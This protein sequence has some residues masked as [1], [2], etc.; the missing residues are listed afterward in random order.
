M[1][2]WIHVRDSSTSVK[3]RLWQRKL[4][5]YDKIIF[6]NHV[7]HC[8]AVV[9]VLLARADNPVR[10]PAT[11]FSVSLYQFFVFLFGLFF[12]TLFFPFGLFFF[13]LTADPAGHALGSIYI[14]SLT[15]EFYFGKGISK[16]FLI[17]ILAKLTT[18]K[19]NMSCQDMSL[20]WNSWFFL[21]QC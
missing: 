5:W 6:S 2:I 17:C 12:L 15:V 11:L 4:F 8:G 14:L 20:L 9:K 13:I 16:P 3:Q 7:C 21:F 19:K 18:R 1:C 10:L